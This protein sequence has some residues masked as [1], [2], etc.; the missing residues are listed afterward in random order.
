MTNC[1]RRH[2]FVLSVCLFVNGFFVFVFVF[3]FVCLFVFFVL[4]FCIF[5][6]VCNAGCVC[7]EGARLFL[8]LKLSSP[9]LGTLFSLL[10][11]W[12]WSL[13]LLR[14][15]ETKQVNEQTKN[16]EQNKTINDF[17]SLI[18]KINRTNV[19]RSL[20]HLISGYFFL[21]IYSFC[22]KSN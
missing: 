22:T 18:Y 21:Y 10:R 7:N 20:I 2:L 14:L 12:P 4:Y 17:K 19:F 6:H 15:L 11:P 16:N 8:L 3:V 1:T 5:L 13:L 9:S